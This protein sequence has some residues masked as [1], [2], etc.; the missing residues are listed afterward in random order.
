[1]LIDAMVGEESHE[2][3]AYRTNGC[4]RRRSAARRRGR[5]CA[6]PYERADTGNCEGRNAEGRAKST[7]A[8]S[9]LCSVAGLLC[10]AFAASVGVGRRAILPGYD[11]DGLVADALLAQLP[12]GFFSLGVAVEYDGDDVLIHWASPVGRVCATPEPLGWSTVPRVKVGNG[13]S[14]TSAMGRDRRSAKGGE[15]TCRSSLISRTWEQAGSA[16]M[17]GAKAAPVNCL[18]KGELR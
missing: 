8:K 11:R 3:A 6:G 12:C 17:L 18:G 9:A 13:L 16:T 15:R 2:T 7:T 5:D 14:Q 4:A 10:D 1:M